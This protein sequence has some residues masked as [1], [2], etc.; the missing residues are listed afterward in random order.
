MT[1]N[2]VTSAILILAAAA[3]S[4][5]FLITR[6]VG[7]VP[8]ND[9]KVTAEEAEKQAVDETIEFVSLIEGIHP[10]KIIVVSSEKAEWPDRCLGLPQSDEIC[11][12]MVVPG[13]RVV[14][15]ADGEIMTFRTNTDGS[16]IRRDLRADNINQ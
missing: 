11:A 12:Q 16:S 1:D 9:G 5:Y 3:L 10:D 8:N 4:G 13:Y 2:K 15:D 14:L 6:N 7:N